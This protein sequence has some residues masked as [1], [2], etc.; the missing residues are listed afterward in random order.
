[1][2]SSVTASSTSP[3]CCCW[4]RSTSASGRFR[5]SL[6]SCTLICGSQTL[7]R[8]KWRLFAGDWHPARAAAD[9]FDSSPSHR[10]NT[11]VSR[12]SFTLRNRAR[13]HPAA[14]HR[15]PAPLPML[16]RAAPHAVRSL[17]FRRQ[18]C[19]RAWQRGKQGVVPF[20]PWAVRLQRLRF[21]PVCSRAKGSTAASQPTRARLAS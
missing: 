12:R 3:F 15:N 13:T 18:Y 6:P 5:A 16:P 2:S 14:A 17:M 11:C 19:S 9:R 4:S 1:M 21:R 8:L 20:A 10:M 7:A